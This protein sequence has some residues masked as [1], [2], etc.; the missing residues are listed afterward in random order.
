MGYRIV[1]ADDERDMRDYYMT[2]LPQLGHE[3]VGA[4][5]SGEELLEMCRARLP[6]V[7]VAD[8]RMEA[9]GCVDGIDAARSVLSSHRVP[10][11]LV[12]GHSS[13][14][15]LERACPEQVQAYLVK[16][17]KR[18]D[19][20]TAIQLARRRFDAME[21]LRQEAADL[22]QSIEQ[23]KTIERAKGFLMSV[24]GLDEPTAYRRLQRMASEKNKRLVEIAEMLIVADEAVRPRRRE[25]E[26]GDK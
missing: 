18:A 10:F 17:I 9:T 19:L 20:E 4:A 11:V 13:P 24:G 12:S 26:E 15:L 25:C 16:P 22:R 14:E 3:L 23:R 2:I 7:V 6:D 5:S 21:R 1:V 8:I